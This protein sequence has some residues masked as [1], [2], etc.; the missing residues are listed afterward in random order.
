MRKRSNYH[1]PVIW[2]WDQHWR[3]GPKVLVGKDAAYQAS[4]LLYLFPKKTGGS[5]DSQGDFLCFSG[6]MNT[7]AASSGDGT[8]V[9]IIAA[10]AKQLEQHLDTTA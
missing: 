6:V 4:P 2:A 1:I 10:E 9:C 7:P 3:H 8:G 5:G